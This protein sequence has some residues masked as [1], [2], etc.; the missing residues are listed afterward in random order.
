M[1]DRLFNGGKGAVYVFETWSTYETIAPS[2]SETVVN[3]GC[4]LAVQHLSS[5]TVELF[6]GSHSSKSIGTYEHKVPQRGSENQS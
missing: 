4:A 6:I 3:F 1:A 2:A 5:T